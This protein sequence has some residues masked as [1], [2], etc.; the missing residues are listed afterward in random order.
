M[1]RLHYAPHT[2]SIAAAILLEEAGI[3]YEPVKVDF[4][5]EEQTR[6]AYLEV[7]PKGRVPALETP[8]GILTETGAILGFVAP[9]MVPDDPWAA[10]KMNELMYYLASTMHVNHAHKMR[11]RRWADELS[12]HADM[13]RKVTRNMSDSCAY[14]N[15]LLP[16][17]P[18]WESETMVISDAY[19]YV[20][21]SWLPGDGVDV[22]RYSNIQIFQHR[23]NRRKSVQA[24]YQKGML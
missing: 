21:L 18:F 10:A 22:T 7:N 20:V 1:Y 17:L 3:A 6:P 9:H 5:E 14:L 11:G 23:M 19:L 4:A 16:T 24:V 13:A 12:S 8:H 15:G 2:I